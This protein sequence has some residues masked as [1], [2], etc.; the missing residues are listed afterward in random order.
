VYIINSVVINERFGPLIGINFRTKNRWNVRMDYNRERN[1]Q[2]A[3]S[4]AQ[5]TELSSQDV[6]VTIGYSKSGMKLPFRDKGRQIV[7]TNEVQIN[8]N[9][10]IRDTRTVQRILD[11]VG[12]YTAGMQD[13]QIRPTASYVVNQRLNVQLYVEHSRNNPKISSSFRRTLTRFGVQLRFNL[14]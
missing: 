13:I 14:A 9:V 12:T 3:V 2:L 6:S 5:I 11:Q 10:T 7:L 8:C 4:N 1:I